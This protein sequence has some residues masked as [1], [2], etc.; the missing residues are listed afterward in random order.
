PLLLG[1]LR[2]ATTPQIVVAECVGRAPVRLQAAC[3]DPVPNGDQQAMA[4][5]IV[6]DGDELTH[7]CSPCLY[8]RSSSSTARRIAVSRACFSPVRRRRAAGCPGAESIPPF[9]AHAASSIRLN[10]GSRSSRRLGAGRLAMSALSSS[11]SSSA[12]L[13]RSQA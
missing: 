4:V 11:A 8:G 7:G 2:L 10:G 13:S 1:K 9:G 12:A 3:A 5:R 6:I